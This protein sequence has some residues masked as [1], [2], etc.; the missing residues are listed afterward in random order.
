MRA[1]S[2]DGAVGLRRVG[3]LVTLGADWIV[4]QG[5]GLDSF[6]LRTDAENWSVSRFIKATAD[7]LPNGARV[8][9]AGGGS[10]PYMAYFGHHR[11]NSCD[12]YTKDRVTYFAD[13]HQ[14]PVSDDAY[15]AIICTQVLEHVPYPHKVVSELFRVLKPEGFLFLT[16]PQ[17]QGLHFEPHHYFNFT[18][19]GLELLF[20]DAG[21]RDISIAERG[22]IFWYWAKRN[23]SFVPYLYRQY[24]GAPKLALFIFYLISAPL[25]KYALPMAFFYLDGIDK[26]KG[27]TL[28]YACTCRK[29]S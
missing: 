13:L 18:R 28:G 24:Q 3:R 23:R 26:K 8:L 7:Q 27:N 22:G 2:G 9:D 25:L 4:G 20:E 17:A 14:L 16:A 5:P 15:D 12:R 6:W 10:S 29:P 1:A 11:Y 21:F 19:Y